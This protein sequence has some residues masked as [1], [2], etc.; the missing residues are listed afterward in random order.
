[1]IEAM[2]TSRKQF[3]LAV[4][5]AGLWMN[6]SEFIRNEILLK[7]YWLDGFNDIGLTFPSAPV[8]G[9]S[10]GLWAMIFAAFLTWLITRFSILQ[11]TVISW[12]LG[13]VL[14]WIA[15]WNLGVLPE[16]ILYWAIPWSF[17]EVYVAGFISRRLM[18]KH[19]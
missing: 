2:E 15:M 6:F 7:E 12:V 4:I 17:A 13:F 9:A 1:M 16:G 8:N 14:L 5:A 19:A 11:S 10:W 18:G 3:V